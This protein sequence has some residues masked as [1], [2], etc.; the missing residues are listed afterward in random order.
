MTRE[1]K[2]KFIEG[3]IKAVKERIL[4]RVDNLPE[5]WEGFELKLYIGDHFRMS[6]A[7][8]EK[9]RKNYENDVIINNL[10]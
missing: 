6:K 4:K 9:R 1:E 3:H 10:I 7:V 5:N 2:Q 8:L